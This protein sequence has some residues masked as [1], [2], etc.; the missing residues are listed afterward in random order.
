MRGADFLFRIRNCFGGHFIGFEP[1][2]CRDD[3]EAVAKAQ[4]LIDG[5]EVELWSGERL[6]IRLE[7]PAKLP[8]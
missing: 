1:M 5:H 8:K 4:R 6:V 2:I 7:C 3:K